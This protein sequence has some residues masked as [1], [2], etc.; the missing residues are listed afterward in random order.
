[1]DPVVLGKARAQ[2]AFRDDIGKGKHKQVLPILITTV[3]PLPP[4]IVWECFGF[5]RREGLQH[6]RLHPL[7]HR[8]P[9]RL[10]HQPAVLAPFALPQRRGEGIQ[11]RSST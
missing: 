8:Q 4:G 5:S 9:D 1:V 10:H 7:R 11:R 6:R 2:Q 3:T